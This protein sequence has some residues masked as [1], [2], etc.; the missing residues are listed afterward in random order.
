MVMAPGD[1]TRDL[2]R[3]F[4]IDNHNYNDYALFKVITV[5]DSSLF[6]RSIPSWE[7]PGDEANQILLCRLK[8]T[9]L[10]YLLH[11]L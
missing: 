10:S 9:D 5:S 3:D 11:K 4:P 6:P 1:L 7:E 8:T 2:T